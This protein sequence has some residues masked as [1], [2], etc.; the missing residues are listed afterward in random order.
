MIRKLSVAGLAA[1]LTLGLTTPSLAIPAWAD[2]PGTPGAPGV[3]DPLFPDLGNGGYDVRHYDLAFDYTP[4]THDFTAKVTILATA[5]QDLSAFNLDTDGHVIDAVTVN[6][7]PATWA[8][9]PGRTGQELTVTPARTLRNHVPFTVEIAYHGNGKAQR[10]GLTGWNFG[11]D[12]GFAAAVQ[13]SRADT[14]MP[15]NDHPSDKA[16]WTFRIT[17]PEGYVATANGEPTGR[18]G[19][20]WTFRAKEPMASEL[21]GLAVVK[22]VYRAGT[23]PHGLPLRHV[24]PAGQEDRYGPIADLTGDQIAWAER[25]F[26]RYPFSTYGIHVYDGYRNALENQ[27][28]SLFGTNWFNRTDGT[29]KY[30]TTMIHEL[31][32]QWFGDSVTPATWQDAWLNEGPAVYY[33]AVWGE[34]QGWDELA[35]KMKVVYDKLD[36]VRAKDGPPGRPKGLGGYNIYDGGA[37]VLYALRQE[38][39]A[40]AFDRI[41]RTWVQRNKDGNASTEDFVAHAVKITHRA[42]LDGFLRAW[43]YGEKNPPM[44]G[45]PDWSAA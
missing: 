27:T 43:L 3:G 34:E 14:F 21:L 42:D 5:T 24:I 39:G 38:A 15:V 10:L 45:H 23:G 32:H 25:R 35:D 7:A 26:G 37:L 44:P 9:A 36:A 6:G 28:L 29:T 22:G 33:A 2:R 19:T 4:G 1:A 8:L 16:T 40:A 13:A 20:T 30:T 17:A 12:G 41:M 11:A 31:V 18:D